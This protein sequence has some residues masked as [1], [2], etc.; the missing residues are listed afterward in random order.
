LF[1]IVG[2]CWKLF[3]RVIGCV[4][5][6]SFCSD[7]LATVSSSDMLHRMQPMRDSTRTRSHQLLPLS[8]LLLHCCMPCLCHCMGRKF[9]VAPLMATMGSWCS[10][11]LLGL[12]D[13]QVARPFSLSAQSCLAQLR[14]HCTIV[15]TLSPFS[16]ACDPN[17]LVWIMP[18][19][20]CVC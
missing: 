19:R 18:P 1:E 10:C 4:I 2:N 20:A 13:A 9:L 3:E 16:Q 8:F 5:L 6:Q 14:R 15:G 12:R 17:Y 11:E 7:W